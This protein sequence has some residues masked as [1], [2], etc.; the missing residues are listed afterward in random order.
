MTRDLRRTGNFVDWC[1]TSDMGLSFL[2]CIC[3]CFSTHF[4]M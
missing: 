4:Y 1:C 3:L 2:G